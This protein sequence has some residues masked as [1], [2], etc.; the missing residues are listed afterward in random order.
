M[1]CGRGLMAGKDTYES[2]VH[3][4]HALW[5]CLDPHRVAALALC[6]TVYGTEFILTVSQYN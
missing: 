2:Q 1:Y 3:F 5:H 6:F 4:I